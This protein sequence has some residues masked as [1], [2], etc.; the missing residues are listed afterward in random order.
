MLRLLDTCTVSDV[1][2]GVE[3]VLRRLKA[4]SPA[5]LAV[6][7]V[8]VMEVEY[9]LALRPEVA[10]QARPLLTDL[11]RALTVAP[12]ETLDAEQ[13][14]EL[15]ARLRRAGTPIGAYDALIAGTA[16]AHGWVLVTSNT[17]EFARVPGLQLEDWRLPER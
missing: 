16:L 17:G 2:C 14:A 10:R 9:G 8:T 15:R 3:P 12:Y 5:S 4:T 7:S 13:T 1:V 11:F 6:S